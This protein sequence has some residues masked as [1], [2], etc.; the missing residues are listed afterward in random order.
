MA[1]MFFLPLL[2]LLIIF[3]W[4]SHRQR[5][6]QQELE[7]LAGTV[8]SITEAALS[9]NLVRLN[10]PTTTAKAC[11]FVEELAQRHLYRGELR[12][13]A[14]RLLQQ[15][16]RTTREQLRTQEQ[17]RMLF[18]TRVG[19]VIVFSM[20]GNFLLSHL[21][22]AA[23]QSHLVPVLGSIV[24]LAGVLMLEKTMPATWFWQ[25][26][27]ISMPGQHW[28]RALFDRTDHSFH[29][30]LQQM[31]QREI[32]HGIDLSGEKAAFLTHWQHEQHDAAKAALRKHQDFFPILELLV[33]GTLATL[34]L[35]PVLR[36]LFVLLS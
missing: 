2:L 20:L 32:T 27:E 26:H 15:A 7:T 21:L 31:Q 17:L 23:P 4:L 18:M 11:R 16:V 25:Q 3:A 33:F 19:G 28:T 14:L 6:I 8:S 36:S 10:T 5:R 35:S 29:P 30:T 9:N 22:A 12:I 34:H 1:G 13:E 24:L